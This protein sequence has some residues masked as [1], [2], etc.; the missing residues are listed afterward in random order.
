MHTWSMYYWVSA[1][2]NVLIE[3]C[4]EVASETMNLRLFLLAS[5]DNSIKHLHALLSPLWYFLE[6]NCI[7]IRYMPKSENFLWFVTAREVSTINLDDIGKLEWIELLI[8]RDSCTHTLLHIK[9]NLIPYNL[10]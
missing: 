2:E 8:N 7:W 9:L 4:S 5:E 6:F 3:V 1:I 10:T